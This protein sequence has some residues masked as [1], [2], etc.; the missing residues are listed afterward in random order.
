M[1][2][3]SIKKVLTTMRNVCLKN[4]YC[5]NCPLHTSI[6]LNTAGFDNNELE[7]AVNILKEIIDNEQNKIIN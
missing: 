4:D 3:K 1:K 7:Q 5:Q 6:C 2:K